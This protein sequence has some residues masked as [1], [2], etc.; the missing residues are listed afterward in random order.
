MD[1]LVQLVPCKR[2][3]LLLLRWF[4]VMLSI[5][6]LNYFLNKTT[7]RKMSAGTFLE[8]QKNTSPFVNFEF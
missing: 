4:N 1:V 3:R 8:G 2:I 7:T 5:G 6:R